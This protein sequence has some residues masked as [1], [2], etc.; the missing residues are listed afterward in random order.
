MEPATGRLHA[1]DALRGSM[2]LLGLALH[3]AASYTVTPLGDSWPYQDARTS[4]VFDPLIFV[5]HL[6]RMPAFFAVAGFF[7]ALLYARDGARGFARNRAKRVLLPLAI[8]WATVGPLI[9]GG[10]YFAITYGGRMT[11]AQLLA[12]VPGS[13]ELA[14]PSPM[15]LWFLWYLVILYAAALAVLALGRSLRVAISA[16]LAAR[17]T[18]SWWGLP[19]WAAITTL[20]LLPMRHPAIDASPLLFP[21]PRPVVAYAV[22]FLFG[23]LLHRGRTDLQRLTMW[24]SWRLPAAMLPI[25]A[26]CFIGIRTFSG[27]AR[28]VHALGSVLVAALT[29]ALV[30]ASFAAFL[31]YAHVEHPAIRYAADAS[32][33]MYIV[34]LPVVIWTAGLLARAPLPASVKFAIVLTVTTA[35]SALTYQTFVRRTWIGEMLNGRRARPAPAS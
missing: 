27:D 34:H 19:L 13:R 12:A 6:F 26:A 23:W 14:N 1:L 9:L 25:V 24:W 18:T 11:G 22:F 32:Y 3:A 16:T 31:R 35:V 29:W 33:W 7:A 28:I 4:A 21:D 17:L 8:F 15:H 2:M 20:T 10:F 5:I 30:L